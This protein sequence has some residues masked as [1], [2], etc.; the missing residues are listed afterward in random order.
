[1]TWFLHHVNMPSPDVPETARFLREVVGLPEG[2]WIYPDRPGE[3]HHD[4]RSIAYFGIENRGI[5]VVRPIPT[6]ATDN[7][8]LHNPTYGGHFALSVEGLDGVIERLRAADV[9]VTDAGIY[10]M[11]GVRQIYCYDPAFNVIEINQVEFPLPEDQL[12]TQDPSADVPL[13]Q[14]SIPAFD[15][16]LSTHFFSNL[17]GLGAPTQAAGLPGLSFRG[18]FG[19]LQLTSPSPG[20]AR[21]TGLAHDPTT[22][23]YYSLSVTDLA[24]CRARLEA[25]GY[26]TSEWSTPDGVQSLL[27]CGPGQRLVRLH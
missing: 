17:V 5:H 8:F 21:G 7:G 1:M 14:V 18:E 2:R 22:T 20:F 19:E 13:S 11:R 12:A 25:D 15:L 27:V 4:A 3:L 23:A 16:D 24:A 6:F 10:A 26:T 9:A